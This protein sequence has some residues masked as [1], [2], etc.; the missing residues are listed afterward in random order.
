MLSTILSG[1]TGK[2]SFAREL[3]FCKRVVTRRDFEALRASRVRFCGNPKEFEEEV[4]V[5]DGGDVAEEVEGE[6]VD[7]DDDT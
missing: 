3:S 1:W 5:D 4:S 7:A 2:G 6:E